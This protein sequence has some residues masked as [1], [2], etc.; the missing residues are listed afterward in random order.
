MTLVSLLDL[1][2]NVST[3]GKGTTRARPMLKWIFA[4]G[5]IDLFSAGGPYPILALVARIPSGRQTH[6]SPMTMEVMP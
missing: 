1:R 2:V 3:P 4:S 6:L 5:A